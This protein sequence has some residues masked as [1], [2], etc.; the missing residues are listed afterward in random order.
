MKKAAVFASF[1]MVLASLAG[2]ISAAPPRAK[3]P[4]SLAPPADS[5]PQKA[6]T[7][8]AVGSLAGMLEGFH[9]QML[10]DDVE[11]QYNAIGGIF[12]R[13][14]AK[15]MKTLMAGPETDR[16]EADKQARKRAFS[17]TFTP[18][19]RNV[20]GFDAMALR[21]EYT[22]SNGEALQYVDW[23]GKRRYFFYFGSVV[24]KD[25]V[26]Q[27]QYR[28]WKIIDEVQTKASFQDIV[29]AMTRQTGATPRILPADEKTPNATA[30]WSDGRTRL[31]AVDFTNRGSYWV[32]YEDYDVVKNPDRY[33]PNKEQDLLALDPQVAAITKPWKP[34]ETVPEKKEEPRK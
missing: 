5:R 15:R 19:G 16:L 4:G 21:A 33:R 34:E 18:L 2:S 22:K 29:N 14:Y 8:A 24:E 31:R 25:G 30:D 7:P 3:A 9:W 23:N 11:T 17:A 12:D 28:L 20:T 26:K 32:V 6:D 13:D 10:R 27:S 1:A